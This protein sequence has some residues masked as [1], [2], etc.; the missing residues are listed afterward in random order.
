VPTSSR[1]AGAAVSVVVGPRLCEKSKSL[2]F[3]AKESER[4]RSQSSEGRRGQSLG[5]AAAASQANE[6]QKISFESAF[7]RVESIVM[8]EAA[9]E[10]GER[11]SLS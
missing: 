10:R 8:V 9:A 6:R 3:E 1:A 7:E 4:E 11:W 5:S 2:H